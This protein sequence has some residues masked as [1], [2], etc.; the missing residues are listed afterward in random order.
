MNLLTKQLADAVRYTLTGHAASGGFT[1]SAVHKLTE[2]LAAFDA[3][4]DAPDAEELSDGEVND[5]LGILDKCQIVP[6]FQALKDEIA[7]LKATDDLTVAYMAGSASRLDELR[8]KDAEIA[9]LRNKLDALQRRT[10]RHSL[11]KDLGSAVEGDAA[12]MARM[13]AEIAELKAVIGRV[14]HEWQVDDIDELE[15]AMYSAGDFRT[16]NDVGQPTTC[17]QLRGALLRKV[18]DLNVEI[19]ALKS[20]RLNL[21]P[22]HD[23]VKDWLGVRHKAR[24]LSSAL[25]DCCAA[26]LTKAIA[27]LQSSGDTP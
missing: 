22:L 17:G 20:E 2:A 27:K 1:R 4:K 11:A 23:L 12:I 9:A 16:G 10:S 6:L 8:A 19:A 26:D 13:T 18:S 25:L 24:P 14:Q 5:A 7:A 15:V 3:A 21:Q